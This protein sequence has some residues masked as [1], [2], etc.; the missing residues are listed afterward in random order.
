MVSVERRFTHGGM[1]VTA[2]GNARRHR[3]TIFSMAARFKLLAVYPYRY[4]VTDGGLASYGPDI[5]D[6]CRLAAG[7]VDRILKGRRAPAELGACA[8]ASVRN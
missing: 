5:A 8:G 7:H 3:A 6:Q 2:T 1:I 4:Y